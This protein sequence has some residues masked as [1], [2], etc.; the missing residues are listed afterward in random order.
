MDTCYDSSMRSKLQ[1]KHQSQIIG[2]T[3]EPFENLIL[4]HYITLENYL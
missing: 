2:E 1:G 3:V 4:K